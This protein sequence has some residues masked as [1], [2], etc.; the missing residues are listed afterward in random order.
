M[1]SH[2]RAKSRTAMLFPATRAWCVHA[3]EKLLYIWQGLV[4]PDR[5]YASANYTG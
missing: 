2:S 4:T 3:D 5:L 1:L